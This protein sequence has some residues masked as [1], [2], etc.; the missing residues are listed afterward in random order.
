MT[1]SQRHS[2][3]PREATIA[4]E[5]TPE[6]VLAHLATLSQPASIRHIAHGM[7]LKHRG[8]RYL[9]RV[10]QKLE[11]HGEVEETQGGRFRLAGTKHAK[12]E[13]AGQ[14]AA[15]KR[16]R[17][18]NAVASSGSFEQEDAG[19]DATA[20][21]V[22]AG[23]AAV[24]DAVRAASAAKSSVASGRGRDPNLVSGRIVAHRD[25]YA[26]LV[27]DSP[28]PRVEGDLFIGRDGLGDAM[29]GDRVL[30]RIERRRAD[31]RAEGRVVQIVQREHPTIVGLFRYGP[32]GNVVLPYDVRILHEVIIP[33]GAELT[34]ALREKIG[35]AGSGGE[36]VANSRT[37][38]PELD[39]AVVNVELTRFPK[40]G[41]A[42]AGRVI[43]ILG[44]PGEIGVDVE[45]I[46]RKHHLPNIF[47][48]EV[49]QEARA[50]QAQVAQSDL[51]GRRDFR[52]LPI[53]TIDG[54]TAR[55]F[56]D[57][58]HVKPLP[59]GHYELQVHIADVAHYVAR[60]SGLDREA[61]LRGTSVYFPNRAVPM[62]PEELSNGICSLN[63][64]VDRLVMSVV[65]ELDEAA[66]LVQADFFQGVIRSAERMT[67]TN[68]NN[69]IEGDAEMTQRYA[70]LV[71]EFQRMKELA[72]L[73]NKRRR[74]RGSID[75]D[76]PEAVIEFDADGRMLSIVRSERN[77][78]HRLI[79]EFMLAA[80]EAVAEYLER[81]GVASLHRVHE[82]PD[83]KKVLEFEELA[84]AFGYSLGVDDLAERRVVVRHGRARPQAREGRGGG[85]GRGRGRMQAMSMTMPAAEEV[86]I[87]PQHYQRL[88]EKIAGKPEERI[89]SY[90]MLRSL[91][92][93]RYA[94]DVLGHF[95][96]ATKEYT[97]FT[98]PIRRYPDLIVHRALKWALENPD[99]APL[100]AHVEN[101]RT[102]KEETVA[103]LGPYRRV[104]LQDIA[105]ESSEAERR[106]DAAERELMEWK[107]AQFMESHLG[108]EYSALI[109]SVQKFGFFVELVEIFV[110]GLVSIDRLEEFTGQ[111]CAY[112][113]RDHSIVC[114]PY[115]G[116]RRGG[117]ARRVFRLGDRVRVR[118]ER[119]DPFRHRVE[120]SLIEDP[121]SDNR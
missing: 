72:L 92:Q 8:R 36:A 9:P 30:A 111:R 70:S 102:G 56:D 119:I 51:A 106:A 10:L 71:S 65:M 115:R 41:L 59:N 7:G 52:N 91:K 60:G 104:E 108:E 31:G 117:G 12:K 38:Y 97:H 50:T 19:A 27:P 73:L 86:D 66:K 43:E 23:R 33:P 3:E 62:L 20:G 103:V 18:A 87:R 44:R 49:Q 39:G 77:I 121:A 26:F 6:L 98:S 64:K 13:A 63:P 74:A 95:A 67:Y 76:L 96:L 15:A 48:D 22:G 25:G 4:D 35:A 55:D 47:P 83:P 88:T 69:V 61:R 58:V 57:A 46:I 81:R 28:M 85:G 17:A 78:A 45:I 54:E 80:N 109:I 53:V 99:V 112:H 75:F 94:V 32:H 2:D 110:E 90:L 82:K 116:S 24:G 5:V 113:D 16:V 101:A 40:G 120:F 107:T 21:A 118:A 105:A 89:L 93:A 100:R 34:P 29:H 68:V 11:K 1:P 84:H 14:A 114:E 79:E 37:R 42:P